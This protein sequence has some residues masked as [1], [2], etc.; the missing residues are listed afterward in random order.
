MKQLNKSKLHTRNP[1]TLGSMKNKHL[2][3]SDHK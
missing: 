1:I 2:K 3:A